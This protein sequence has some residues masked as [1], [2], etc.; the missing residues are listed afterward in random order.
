MSESVEAGGF[1]PR[2]SEDVFG[3]APAE[4][5]TEPAGRPEPAAAPDGVEQSGE[6]AVAPAAEPKDGPVRDAA[7][8]FAPK[9][10][11]EPQQPV[12]GSPPAE[13]PQQPHSIPM[14]AH[15]E[16]RRKWQA[17]VRE[18]EARATQ[19]P[20]PMAPQQHAPQPPQQPQQPPPDFWADPDAHFAYRERQLMQRQEEALLHTRLAISEAMAKQLPEFD[21]A[22]QALD[23]FANADPR[24]KEAVRQQMRSQPV[25][26]QWAYEFGKQ[27]M[28]RQKWQPVM[29]QHADPDA[30]INAEVERR[31]AE[32]ANTRPAP[33]SA[34]PAPPVSLASARSAAPRSGQASWTG[35]APPE[36]VWG[37]R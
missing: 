6:A 29:Q 2:S 23:E 26:A 12:T 19:P 37:R 21:A 32:R 11:E 30:Y 22:V 33:S 8:R 27:I 18:L 1:V 9:A 16:E 24:N 3:P 25:P 7:G 17:K 5:R 28:A 4:R 10:G 13:P 34:P 31:L 15:L 14:S 35:P 20:A 36:A